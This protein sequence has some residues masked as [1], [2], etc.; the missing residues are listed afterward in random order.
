MPSCSFI[1]GKVVE[2]EQIDADTRLPAKIVFGKNCSLFVEDGD[3]FRAVCTMRGIHIAKRKLGMS[4]AICDE[5]CEVLARNSHVD[6]IIPRNWTFMANRTKQRTIVNE[7]SQV[8]HPADLIK[9]S[10]HLELSPLKAFE[11]PRIILSKCDIGHSN[12]PPTNVSGK[13]IVAK[14]DEALGLFYGTC[15]LIIKGYKDAHHQ[16]QHQRIDRNVSVCGT[17][18]PASFYKES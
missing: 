2:G 10:K 1:F 3:R 12:P 6:I 9:S 13:A 11:N 14:R 18:Q 17:H 16:C 7:V 8:Q 4:I 15:T 5:R